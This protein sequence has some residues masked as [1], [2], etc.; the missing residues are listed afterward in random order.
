MIARVQFSCWLGWAALGKASAEAAPRSQVVRDSSVAF[1]GDKVSPG[2][3]LRLDPAGMWGGAEQGEQPGLSPRQEVGR[4][5]ADC[6]G[7][8]AS[9]LQQVFNAHALQ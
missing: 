1:P 4:A 5:A 3:C 8:T 7:T 2:H 9:L 6:K